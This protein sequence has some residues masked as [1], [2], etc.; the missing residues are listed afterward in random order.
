MEDILRDHDDKGR[1]RKHQVDY[2]M[3][4]MFLF[5]F[6]KVALY[7]H[8]VASAICK[9]LT[10]QI[11]QNDQ[12]GVQSMEMLKV[13]AA[14][15]EKLKRKGV[16]RSIAPMPGKRKKLLKPVNGYCLAF[17]FLKLCCI[18]II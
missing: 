14:L 2:V 13:R 1:K 9:S 6:S 3:F 18:L 12:V 4:D 5:S 8:F 10:L 11:L 16:F 7:F 17:K 15:E